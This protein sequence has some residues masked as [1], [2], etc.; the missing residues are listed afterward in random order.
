MPLRRH[1]FLTLLAGTCGL[2]LGRLSAS[3][4]SGTALCQLRHRREDSSFGFLSRRLK[5]I[6]LA[7][8]RGNEVEK[9]KGNQIEWNQWNGTCN[10]EHGT[11]SRESSYSLSS[12]LLSLLSSF[13]P[14]VA[15]VSGCL[16]RDMEL[17]NS[18]LVDEGLHLHPLFHRHSW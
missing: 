5:P 15:D 17:V 4:T 9:G 16:K 2:L 3:R 12:S 18:I 13:F 11:A 6:H 14:T 10:M 1:L 7:P 8:A